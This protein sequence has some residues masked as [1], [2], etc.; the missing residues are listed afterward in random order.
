MS[1]AASAPLRRR[2]SVTWALLL[3]VAGFVVGVLLATGVAV[4]MGWL[5]DD[6]RSRITI[7]DVVTDA[8]PGF[9]DAPAPSSDACGDRR[10]CVEAVEGDS[11]SIYRFQS[12]DLAR[13]AVIYN[14]GDF[15]RSD[16][17]VVEFE[18][19]TSADQR[20][21]LIQVIEGTW[22]GSDD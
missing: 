20:F 5:F 4:V 13:Q 3:L 10:G 1:T 16:R 12:I 9:R 19:G 8:V 21:G 7:S 11:A 2:V 18:E 14:D 15:Y 17:F 22:T 6:S